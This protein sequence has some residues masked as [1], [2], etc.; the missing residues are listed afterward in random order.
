MHDA[1]VSVSVQGTQLQFTRAPHARATSSETFAL[2]NITH[3]TSRCSRTSALA[4]ITHR[5]SRCSGT[6]A[7]ANITHRASCCSEISAALDMCR[8][9]SLMLVLLLTLHFSLP[10]DILDSRTDCPGGP[11]NCTEEVK[12]K[13]ATRLQLRKTCS[14]RGTQKLPC[15]CCKSC[16][17]EY[18][19]KCGG[20]NGKCTSD[21]I[22]KE[23]QS[24][25][26]RCNCRP[27]YPNCR[28]GAFG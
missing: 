27:K 21:L 8:L 11:P 19:E 12:A 15:A 16:K 9:F 6:S 13:C 18:G 2:A 7:L 14:W 26:F 22:C 24:N 23:V 3:R 1:N 5:V 4:N 25:D 17:N 20:L 28:M 10:L